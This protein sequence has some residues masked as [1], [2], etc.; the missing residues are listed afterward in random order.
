MNKL[1]LLIVALVVI[2]L[3]FAAQCLY[4]VK[5]YES[6]VQLRFGRMVDQPHRVF[7]SY[8]LYLKWPSFID[9]HVPIDN[10]LQVTDAVLETINTSGR[11]DQNFQAGSPSP[12]P[13]FWP[14]WL[15]KTRDRA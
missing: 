7:S 4:T 13:S 1:R 9:R 10:R 12:R 14:R 11:Q 6:V 5:P 8:N 3:L 15:R 2:A